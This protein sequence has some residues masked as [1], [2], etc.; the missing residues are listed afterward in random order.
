MPHVTLPLTHETD[1]HQIFADVPAADL[2][3]WERATTLGERARAEINKYWERSEYPLHLV[4]DMASHG[5]LS[6]G[7]D[8]MQSLIV[9]KA[10]TGVSAFR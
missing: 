9:G 3:A 1:F 5:L 7:A 10:I 6:D 8:S 2:A 4:Q